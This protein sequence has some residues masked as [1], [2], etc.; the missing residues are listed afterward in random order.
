MMNKVLLATCCVLIS[1]VMVMAEG[2]IED[3]PTKMV[4][5]VSEL[6]KDVKV[7]EEGKWSGSQESAARKPKAATGG[8][9]VSGN[10]A[11]FP[12]EGPARAFDGKTSTKYCI[13]TN[14][15][16][17][18]Y[19]YPNNSKHKVVTYAL[20]S[21]NDAPERDP[22]D[23]KLLGSNDGRKWDELDSRSG[24]DFSKRHERRTFDV[25]KPGEY[26]Y[27]KLDV[28]ANHGDVSSQIAEIE[29]ITKK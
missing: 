23:W 19:Q 26:S 21:A 5:D 22:R 17:L 27:Y 24:E 13:N 7:T 1:C 28:S 20:N 6:W 10:G 14:T 29:L 11:G 15:M 4:T 2:G 12:G 9:A 16:W 18:Q 3:Y 25:A 8:A